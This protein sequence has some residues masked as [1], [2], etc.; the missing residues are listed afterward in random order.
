MPA[1]RDPYR[2]NAHLDSPQLSGIPD[3]RSLAPAWHASAACKDEADDKLFF[4]EVSPFKLQRP[5]M[6]S[7][8]SLLLPLLTCEMC[9]VR[10]PCL[11]AAL[12][13]PTFTVREDEHKALGG[14]ESKPRVFGTWGGTHEGDRV[15][16]AHLPID[17][18]I[19]ELERTFPGRL[20]ARLAAYTSER[21]RL[22]PHPPSVGLRPRPPHRRDRRIDELLAKRQVKT[23]H[24]RLGPGPGRGRK[25]P[26]ALYAEEHGVSRSTAWRRLKAA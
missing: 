13:P 2:L 10:R 21:N 6:M 9:P 22:R 3:F 18:A 25:G 24:V 1:H 8:P 17:E 16:V 7:L 11:R 4:Q 15:A 14:R 26:I 23:S 5:A 20:A 19:E 12:D